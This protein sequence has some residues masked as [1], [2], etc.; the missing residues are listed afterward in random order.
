MSKAELDAK[1]L[2]E[3][4]KE[5]PAETQERIEYIIQGALLAARSHEQQPREG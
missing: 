5:L 3:Q 2:A 1:W 4:L